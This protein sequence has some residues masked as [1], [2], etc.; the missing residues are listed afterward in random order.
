MA[1][2]TTLR[3]GKPPRA[4]RMSSFRRRT[5]TSSRS[6]LPRTF[7]PR[8]KRYGSKSSSSVEKLFEW[9]LWGVAER[10]RR[11]SKRDPKSRTARVVFVSMP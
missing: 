1:S 10:N 9:P 8:V 4:S 11:C 3:F 2:R 6:R 7:T 5:I